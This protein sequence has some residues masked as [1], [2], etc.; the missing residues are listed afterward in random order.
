MAKGLY[1]GLREGWRRAFDLRSPYGPLTAEDRQLLAKLAAKVVARRMTMP[2]VLFLGSV[3]PL[4]QVGSQALVFLRPFLVD[5]FNAADY[6][7][8]VQILDRRE[9][10]EA[11]VDEIEAAE[12]IYGKGAAK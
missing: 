12:Q 5:I 7:R 11:L 10:L 1:H 3:R 8:L 9:G 6:D 4:N 2:A